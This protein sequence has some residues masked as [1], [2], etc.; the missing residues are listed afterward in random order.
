MGWWKRRKGEGDME[1]W[2]KGE[3]GGME[4][5]GREKRE[6]IDRKE[7]EIRG[8]KRREGWGKEEREGCEKRRQEGGLER[9]GE[10][11]G[12]RSIGSKGSNVTIEE[13]KIEDSD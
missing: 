2:K 12:E 13:P 10:W 11:A 1:E 4:E 3:K 9:G 5:W 7:R 6:G 8:W